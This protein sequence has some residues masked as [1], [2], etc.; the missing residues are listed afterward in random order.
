[1]KKIVL[2]S[3]FCLF[4]S[5]LMAQIELAGS[6]YSGKYVDPVSITLKDGF[7]VPAGV[8]FEAVIFSTTVQSPSANHNYIQTYNARKEGVSNFSTNYDASELSTTIEYLDAMG[9]PEQTVALKATPKYNDIVQ[10]YLYNYAGQQPVKF[11]PYTTLFSTDNHGVFR[12]NA[13]AETYYFHQKVSQPDF[14]IQSNTYPFAKARIE[15]SEDAR[16]VEQGFAYGPEGQLTGDYYNS[17]HT[18]KTSYNSG[19][20]VALYTANIDLA[21]GARTLNRVNNNAVY[22]SLQIVETT[23]K[24]ENW[25]PADG[26]SGITREYHDKDGRLILRRQYM[27][28]GTNVEKYSTYYVYDDFGDLIFVL[29][30]KAE[31]DNTTAISQSV[32]DNLCYQ[33]MYDGR[34]R[35]IE[36]KLPGKDREYFVFNDLDQVILT[37]D[38]RQRAMIPDKQWSV[39]KYDGQGRVI[40]TGTCFLNDTRANIQLAANAVAAQFED[41]IYSAATGTGYTSA[42]YPT[43]G[44]TNLTIN[45]Y[46][47][48]QFPGGNPYP[49]SGDIGMTRGLLTG[50]KTAI[51]GTTNMLWH[52]TYYD[53]KG[54]VIRNFKQHYKGGG[55]PN[56]GNYDDYTNTYD[57][58]GAVL[59]TLRVHKVNNVQAFSSLVEFEYGHTGKLINT[60]E[61]ING[62]TRTLLSQLKYSDLWHLNFD[63]LHSVNNGGSFIETINSYY[64][65]RNLPKFT[66][67]SQHNIGYGTEYGPQYNG[68]LNSKNV[69]LGSVYDSKSFVYDKLNRLTSAISYQNARNETLTYDK[70][71]NILTLARTGVDYGTLTYTYKNSGLSNQIASITGTN[72]SRAYDYDQNG[73]ATTDGSGLSL[74][75]NLLD[76]P[77]TVK[78][79]STLKSDYVYTADAQKLRN[80]IYNPSGNVVYEYIDGIVYVNGSI[81]FVQ[82]PKGRAVPNGGQYKYI[83]DL[84]DEQGNVWGSIDEYQGFSRI[85]QQDA[86][87]AFGLR[88]AVSV[89]GNENRYLYNGKEEQQVLNKQYDYGA[90]FYDPVIARWT[91]VDPLGEKM[92]RWSPYNYG[93]DN[94]IR[95]VDPDGMG[96]FDWYKDKFGNMKYDASV[97]NQNNVNKVSPGGKYVGA[98]VKTKDAT[99]YKNGAVLFKN[100]TKAYQFMW[101]NGN[102]GQHWKEEMESFAWIAKEGVAVLPTSGKKWNGEKFQ[103]DNASGA[104][105]VYKRTGEGS[106][107]TVDFEGITLH[108]IADIHLHPGT[109]AQLNDEQPSGTDMSLYRKLKI[110]GLVI[111]PETVYGVSPTDAKNNTYNEIGST[112]NLLKGKLLIIPNIKLLSK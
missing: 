50:T 46:D 47:S 78:A 90:R 67:S 62:G 63:K 45:Y 102:V 77:S 48:Y 70:N 75:Y 23:I 98:E 79:G 38:G 74:E 109:R 58:T 12:D 51:L 93:F 21:T 55:T 11:I 82:T 40:L 76:L 20:D 32:L 17:G 86:Y 35:L 10:T 110:P 84:A 53:K 111:G 8:S 104:T 103:N 44:I 2:L 52:V 37:Q 33:Y 83:Y 80:T 69:S 99:Y 91:S 3:F 27:S 92:R 72:F 22:G 107:L 31:P 64:T 28:N 29:P 39:T 101:N 56:T 36:K 100:E 15:D 14:G 97:K 94:P 7:S 71:G 105:D 19:A 73:N 42:T 95:F 1:M 26:E 34:H 60:W 112:M 57:F 6:G 89:I 41:R 43:S 81:S 96:P 68:N 85:I 59:T 18:I 88:A 9:R 87:Y 5:N 4:C 25:T 24:D 108:P 106:S 66:Y 16:V 49:I 65:A 61:T 13:V 54:N 30:P